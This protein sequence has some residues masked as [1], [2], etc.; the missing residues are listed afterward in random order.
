MQFLSKFSNE[1]FIKMLYSAKKEKGIEL[2]LHELVFYLERQHIS[3]L[4]TNFS[5]PLFNIN[6]YLKEILNA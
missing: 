1:I 3:I 4:L 6:M 5:L 2:S